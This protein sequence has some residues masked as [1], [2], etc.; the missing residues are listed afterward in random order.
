MPF[1]GMT[2]LQAAY[3]AA[4][5]VSFQV[6]DALEQ[7]FQDGQFDLL[8]SIESG[9]HMHDKAKELALAECA[10]DEYSDGDA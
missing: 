4:F 6:A 3:D 2:N 10:D 5:K 8:W 9:E 1:E 7:P